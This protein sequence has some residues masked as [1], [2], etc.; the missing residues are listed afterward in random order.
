[1]SGSALRGV[2]L[3]GIVVAASFAAR[4]LVGSS[5]VGV[6][7]PDVV[8]YRASAAVVAL[9]TGAALGLSGLLLQALLRNPLASPFILGVSSGAGFGYMLALYIGWRFGIDI[10]GPL[11]AAL[12]VAGPVLA[13]TAGGLLAL[14]LVWM[15]GCRDGVPEPLSIVLAGVV[16]GAIAAAATTAVQ[17][18]VPSGLR[19]DFL[20]WMM[21][22]IPEAPPRGLLAAVVA[23]AAIG[24]ALAWRMGPGL[25]AASTSDDEAA[26]MGVALRPQRIALFTLAGL[27]AAATVPL[28]GPIAFVGLVGPHLTRLLLGARHRPL[29]L[30]APMAGAA[31]LLAA[32]ALRQLVDLGGGRL[33]VGVVTTLIGGPVFLLLLRRSSRGLVG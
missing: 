1:M 20:G 6:P 13:A 18:I 10:A 14:A 28:T 33:P 24:I 31:M 11:A 12:G 23:S 21:G 32:D 3:L 25:D 22:R 2:L 17:S 29:A 27:L 8:G 9:S 30:G 15:L 26:S 16:V 19:G 7:A 4:I 5:G